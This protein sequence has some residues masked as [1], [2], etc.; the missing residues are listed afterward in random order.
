MYEA[1]PTVIRPGSKIGNYLRENKV[2]LIIVL[3]IAA[4]LLAQEAGLLGGANALVGK[5]APPLMLSTPDG[6][7]VSLAEH[8]GKDV[9]VLDFFATWCPPCRESLPHLA[10]MA[11]D[12]AGRNV[13]IYA[14]NVGESA[15]V[16]ESY[17]AQNNLAL[18][19]LMD[20]EGKASEAY[21]V[22]GIPQQVI[23]GK[24]GN[25]DY[26]GVGFSPGDEATLR[27]RID[28]LLAKP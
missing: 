6:Q 20:D 1:N 19:A 22:N 15:A 14:V 28:A 2:F 16:A 5:A 9:V 7:S 4:T 11:S 13:A 10:A 24:D 8:T 25:V 12:Y 23:I 3:A 21:G 26:I 27:G 18:K 17:L